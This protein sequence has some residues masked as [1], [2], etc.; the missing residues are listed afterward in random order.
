MWKAVGAILLACGSQ[1]YGQ[2]A[3]SQMQADARGATFTTFDIPGSLQLVP[4]DINPAGVIS[5]G[6]QDASGNGHGFLRA[7]DGA[8]T[9]ID[10]PGSNNG[11]GVN[12]IN[13]AGTVTGGYFGPG[14]LFHGYLRR[15]NGIF[16][17]FDPPDSTYTQADRINPRG[18]ITGS[19]QDAGGLFHGFLRSPDGEIVTFDPPVVGFLL[20]LPPTTI[21]TE[22]AITG[23]YC[24]DASCNSVHG[25][26]R[27]RD[28][29]LTTIDAPGKNYGT[30]ATGINSVGTITG[31]YILADFSAQHGFLRTRDGEFISFDPPDS[32]A[33]NPTGINDRGMI[34]GWYCDATGCHGFV[35]T[36]G[37]R[38]SK[39]DF[40]SHICRLYLATGIIFRGSSDTR[41][42]PPLK[43]PPEE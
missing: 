38:S 8:F 15:S 3:H 34:T 22:G 42:K 41:G 31:Y 24:D 4:T 32:G 19:Y 28:G 27:A 10:V 6:Y 18:A 43:C 40:R 35:R 30:V 36:P 33:T 9:I 12:G 16:T 23:S 14:S 2:P 17:T 26:L 25:F 11:T 13:P 1:L 7:P 5:A 29:T 39:V 21:N 20:T 37:T